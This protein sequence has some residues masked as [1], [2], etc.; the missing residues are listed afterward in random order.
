MSQDSLYQ[1]SQEITKEGGG[2]RIADPMRVTKGL[3]NQQFTQEDHKALSETE[4]EICMHV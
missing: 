3:K 1:S 2:E 4:K